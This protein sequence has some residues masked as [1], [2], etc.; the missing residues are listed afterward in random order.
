MRECRPSKRGDYNICE[1]LIVQGFKT[2]GA[3]Q[4]LSAHFPLQRYLVAYRYIDEN[5]ALSIKAFLDL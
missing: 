3:T 5:G 2:A 4:D 1:K